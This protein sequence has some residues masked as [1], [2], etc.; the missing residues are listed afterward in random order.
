MKK[1]LELCLRWRLLVFV[2]VALV[3]VVGIRSALRLPI[4]AVPDVTNVHV[5]PQTVSF[6]IAWRAVPVKITAAKTNHW[7][8]ALTRA[9]ICRDHMPISVVNHRT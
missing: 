1:I 4:D 5:I 7:F 2:G 3:V 6:E 8:G 9:C